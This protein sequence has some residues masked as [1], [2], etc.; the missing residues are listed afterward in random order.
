[1]WLIF[2]LFSI[3]TSAYAE[4]FCIENVENETNEPYLSYAL[5]KVVEKA[6]LENGYELSCKGDYKKINVSV[7]SFEEKPIAYTPQQRVSSY[8]L[9]LRFEVELSG[10]KFQI[11]GTVP[12]SLPSGGLGDIPRRKAIDD[13]LDKIYLDLLKNLRR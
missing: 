3:I 2:L 8:N 1:M 4:V 6:V 13:L 7:L 9:T 5:L 11:S 10:R 12:Y